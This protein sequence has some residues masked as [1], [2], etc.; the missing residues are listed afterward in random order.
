MGSDIRSITVAVLFPV[1]SALMVQ[2][3]LPTTFAQT[4]T[5]GNGGEVRQWNV[6]V[7]AVDPA[8]VTIGR[9]FTA[10]IYENLLQEVAKT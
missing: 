10:A 5:S 3:Y 6:Q 7:D 2:L 9:S 4:P 1:L 8:D